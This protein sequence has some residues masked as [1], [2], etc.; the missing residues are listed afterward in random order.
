MEDL[1]DSVK[2]L[3]SKTASKSNLERKQNSTYYENNCIE[4]SERC[5]PG[6]RVEFLLVRRADVSSF[7]V[8]VGI[9]SIRNCMGECINTALFYCRSLQFN[10]TTNEC[11]LSDESS[12]V[13][14]SS[15]SLDLYEAYCSV[16]TDS[17]T[18][19]NRPYSFEKIMASRIV[20][21][22]ILLGYETPDEAFDYYEPACPTE[23][24]DARSVTTLTP[25]SLDTFQLRET[26]RTL[27]QQFRNVQHM[28]TE[29]L[30]TCWLLCRN[31][32]TFVCR[33]FSYSESRREC[34]VSS[35]ELDSDLSYV[36]FTQQSAVFDLYVRLA[37][38]GHD[39]VYYRDMHSKPMLAVREFLGPNTSAENWK[40][41]AATADPELQQLAGFES[42]PRLTAPSEHVGFVPPETVKVR[43]ECHD[44]GMNI[45]FLLSTPD[46]DKVVSAVIVMSND[47]VLPHD[48]TT[49]DDLFFHVTC[50]YTTSTVNE[51]RQGI[52]VGG[53]SPIAIAT[54]EV[55]RQISLQIMKEGRPVDSVFIG[56]TLVARVASEISRSFLLLLR[57]ILWA[58]EDGI[59]QQ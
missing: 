16:T 54:S 26:N 59:F 5:P 49:K 33:T 12:D 1:D 46:E 57:Y 45:S 37:A 20:N 10:P 58:S 52:V 36:R 3:L 38:A 43:A 35:N 7:G 8:S 18:N 56:E 21:A 32:T 53:P 9:R 30:G 48:V 15:P 11:F 17:V 24:H 50:N 6:A 19:C 13:A 28:Q 55:H 31:A 41:M 4:P 34:M 47:R 25:S 2:C 42:I 39:G 40:L 29:N 27:R 51:I 44:T 22:S 23:A 14:V